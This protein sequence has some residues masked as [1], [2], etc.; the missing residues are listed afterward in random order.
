MR[1]LPRCNYPLAADNMHDLQPLPAKLPVMAMDAA[2]PYRST[3]YKAVVIDS[4][5]HPKVLQLA[6]VIANSFAINEPMARHIQP[7]KIPPATLHDVKHID[8]FGEDYFGEWTKENIIYWVIRLFI[9]TDPGRPLRNI[10]IN[11]HLLTHTLAM[12]ND[13][14]EIIGGAFNMPAFL[15]DVEQS[16]R[17]DDPFMDAAYS[18]FQRIHYL[19]I[20]QES[21]ALNYLSHSYTDFKTALETGKV[22]ILFMIARSPLLP[23]EDTFELVAAS[24]ERFRELGYEYV[25]TAAANQWTGAA[26]ELPGAVRVHYAPYRLEK[27]VGESEEGLWDVTWSKDG[28]LSDKDSGCMFYV[29]RIK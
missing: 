18:F 7:S 12:L 11:E 10:E 24:L 23:T 15:A 28:Y 19:L 1:K 25:V 20:S 26:F 3:K 13:A 6:R 5:N 4:F 22:G 2:K 17:T 16:L 14:G 8:P 21:V 29:I 9:L 27:Q